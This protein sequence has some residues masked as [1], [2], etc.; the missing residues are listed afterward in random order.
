MIDPHQ[1][2]LGFCTIRQGEILHQIAAKRPVF[3]HEV[4]LLRLAKRAINVTR[5]GHIA[6]DLGDLL[7]GIVVERLRL[8]LLE[9]AYLVAIHIDERKTDDP[10]DDEHDPADDDRTPG[11]FRL[12]RIDHLVAVL[13]RKPSS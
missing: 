9:N 7:P 1:V 8:I 2:R 3:I 5:H 11:R 6:R 10:K 4:M 12:N 13:Q